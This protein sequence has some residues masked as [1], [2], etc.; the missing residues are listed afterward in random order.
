M[1]NRLRKYFVRAVESIVGLLC[2]VTAVL[3]QAPPSST[4]GL[5]PTLEKFLIAVV[6]A[7]LSLLTGYITFN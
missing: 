1:I 2:P 6:S 3:A 5:D 4:A 7:V